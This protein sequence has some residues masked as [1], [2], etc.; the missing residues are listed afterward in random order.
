MPPTKWFLWERIFHRAINAAQNADRTT[1]SAPPH[2]PKHKLARDAQPARP[3]LDALTLYTHLN[4]PLFPHLHYFCVL[5]TLVLPPPH[6]HQRQFE[7]KRATTQRRVSSY[8]WPSYGTPRARVENLTSDTTC[9]PGS[10]SDRRAQVAG[11]APEAQV[12]APGAARRK[13]DAALWL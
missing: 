1:G 6:T 4:F 12:T 8:R 11:G 2:T 3:T 9:R 13:T 10:T 5:Q 7:W